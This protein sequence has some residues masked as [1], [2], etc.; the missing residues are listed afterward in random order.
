MQVCD[1]ERAW[2]TRN[3]VYDREGKQSER[4]GKCTTGIQVYDKER[5]ARQGTRV[6]HKERELKAW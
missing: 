2:T 3:V 1:R 6:N 5:S 4:E